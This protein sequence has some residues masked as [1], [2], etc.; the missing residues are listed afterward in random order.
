MRVTLFLEKEKNMQ[1]SKVFFILFSLFQVII[2]ENL[3]TSTADCGVDS[4]CENGRCTNPFEMGCLRYMAKRDG[5]IEREFKVRVCNSDDAALNSTNCRLPNFDYVET[6]IS[7]QNWDMGE[8]VSCF[9]LK[10][11]WNHYS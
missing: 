10:A 7:L 11:S 4:E 3:C 6:R 2:G 1:G 5:N 9:L 8:W